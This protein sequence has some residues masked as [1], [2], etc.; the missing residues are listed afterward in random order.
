MSILQTSEKGRN[1]S[2]F[3][4]ISNVRRTQASLFLLRVASISVWGY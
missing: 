1:R 2:I 3:A 4:G